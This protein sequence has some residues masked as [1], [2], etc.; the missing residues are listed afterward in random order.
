MHNYGYVSYIIFVVQQRKVHIRLLDTVEAQRLL[1]GVLHI[2]DI[3]SG[4]LGVIA[5]T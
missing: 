2:L 4:M 3:E 5:A 1:H